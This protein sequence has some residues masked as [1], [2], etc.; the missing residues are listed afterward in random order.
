MAKLNFRSKTA[1]TW[2][3]LVF[4]CFVFALNFFIKKQNFSAIPP[5]IEHKLTCPIDKQ[6][7]TSLFTVYVTDKKMGEIARDL[8]CNDSVVMRQYGNVAVV[9][10]QSDYDTFRYINYGIADLAL[11]KSNVVDAFNANEAQDLHAIA[12]YADYDAYFIAMRE[13]PV[14]SKEYLLDKRIGLLDYPTSRSGHIIPKSVFQNLGMNESAMALYYFNSHR[15]LRNKLEQG[16][17]DIIA[18]Y[19]SESDETRFSASYSTK[20]EE[21][22]SGV[23]WYLRHAERNPDLRCALSRII[24]EAGKIHDSSYYRQAQFTQACETEKVN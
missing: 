4:C 1:L 17:V 11:V 9:L 3:V 12:H 18:S 23:R 14:V 15:E 22:V 20:I 24:V 10:G 19:W 7:N 16:E 6:H 2:M 13:K 5:L 8:L 21:T